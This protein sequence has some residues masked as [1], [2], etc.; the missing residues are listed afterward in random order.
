MSVTSILVWRIIKLF[1]SFDQRRLGITRAW[2]QIIQSNSRDD[3]KL[4]IKQPATVNSPTHF[5][6]FSISEAHDRHVYENISNLYA[7]DFWTKNVNELIIFSTKEEE[8]KAA[9]KPGRHWHFV[10]LMNLSLLNN[11]I[12]VNVFK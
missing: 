7:S 11:S 3:F 1:A 4:N 9:A 2:L 8:A 10:L 12:T 5:A 6:E